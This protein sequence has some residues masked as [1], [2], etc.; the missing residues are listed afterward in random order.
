MKTEHQY[1]WLTRWAGKMTKTRHHATE[2]EIRK[3]H[4]EAVRVEGTLI[5]R[6]VPETE[7]ERW[8]QF[9]SNSTGNLGGACP[10]KMPR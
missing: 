5:I 1:L 3:L 2:E 6:E 8:A 10:D 4:P 9:R 7:N